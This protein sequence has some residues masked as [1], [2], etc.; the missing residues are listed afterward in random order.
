MRIGD[1]RLMLASDGGRYPL[2]VLDAFS[3]D[4]VPT[5]LLTVEAFTAYLEKLAPDG[6]IAVNISN[7]FI[8]LLPILA[9]AG[10]RLGLSV[11]WR[12]DNTY[13]RLARASKWVALA[14]SPERLASLIAERGWRRASAGSVEPWTDDRSDLFLPLLWHMEAQP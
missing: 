6:V 1:G 8:D 13:D 3:S 11:A 9:A 7:R 4:A 5:H 14:R 2:I 12:F 10:E